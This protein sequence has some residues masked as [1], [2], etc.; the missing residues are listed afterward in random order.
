MVQFFFHSRTWLCSYLTVK[1]EEKWKFFYSIW[2]FKT[3]YSTIFNDDFVCMTIVMMTRWELKRWGGKKKK[4]SVQ[5]NKFGASLLALDEHQLIAKR[6]QHLLSP[7]SPPVHPH[8]SL[9]VASCTMST[10]H[11]VHRK[12]TFISVYLQ[13][14]QSRA[15]ASRVDLCL[16]GVCDR[17]VY[18]FG[19]V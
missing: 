15:L 2:F 7:H 10:S 5:I 14:E 17:M 8:L 11:M 19:F 4:K 12:S 3:S 6:I 1:E 13:L 18:V 9:H 16:F